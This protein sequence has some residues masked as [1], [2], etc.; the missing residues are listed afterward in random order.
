MIDEFIVEV[1]ALNVRLVDV[2]KFT[3]FVAAKV[4]VL[5]PRLI[6]LTLLLL[7]SKEPAVTANPAVV[8]VPLLTVSEFEP[9]F[10]APAS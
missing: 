8:N 2:A 1:P 10:N 7:D 3:G 9:I 4:N 6:V 5:A